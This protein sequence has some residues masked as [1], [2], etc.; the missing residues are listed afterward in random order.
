MTLRRP[1]GFTY[2]FLFLALTT[3]RPCRLLQRR[4][5][6]RFAHGLA[7]KR[8]FPFATKAHPHSGQKRIAARSLIA[9]A[10][11]SRYKNTSCAEPATSRWRRCFPGSSTKRRLARAVPRTASDRTVPRRI[12]IASFKV[13]KSA[14]VKP[15]GDLSRKEL[16]TMTP[17]RRPHTAPVSLPR[18]RRY[19]F[20]RISRCFS[21]R[22]SRFSRASR[23]AKPS[24][25]RTSDLPIFAFTSDA[26]SVLAEFFSAI[27]DLILA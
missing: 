1:W 21:S 15:S 10:A 27:F 18:A 9:R 25:G 20:T 19:S 14:C 3:R 22:A 23:T 4:Y 13:S 6:A 2:A 11:W 17:A 8:R 24:T 7:Q 16:C 5:I 12:W 26:S